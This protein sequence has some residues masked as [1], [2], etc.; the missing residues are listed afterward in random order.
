MAILLENICFAPGECSRLLS[1]QGTAESLHLLEAGGKRVAAKGV[2]GRWH[3]HLEME[4]T[5]F[6]KG[7]GIRYV[8]DHVGTFGDMDCVLL[9]SHLPHCWMEK[10]NT[11]GYVLQFYLPPEHPLRSMGGEREIAPLFARSERGL[12]FTA[13]IATAALVVLQRMAGASRLARAGLLLE[14]LALLHDASKKHATTL[15]HTRVFAEAAAA[16]RPRLE[17]V[18][19]W[20]LEQF[21]EPLTLDEAVQRSAMSRATFCRQFTR[22][23]GRTFIAFVTEARL[24]YAHQ[25]LTQTQRSIADIA[26][27]SGFG[28]LTRFNA[29]FRE[30]FGKAPR[31]IR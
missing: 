28:S 11:D 9:G 6:Q 18:V 2:G 22:H 4:F 29:T 19:Q 30:K 26:F 15:G 1:W 14:L 7:S 20:V 12:H 21:P 10:G 3:S 25:L 13:T 23:T 5:I 27:A 24:A 16:T 31:E 17:A 8:G